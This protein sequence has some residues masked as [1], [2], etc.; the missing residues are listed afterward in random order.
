MVYR[1]AYSDV[2]GLGCFEEEYNGEGG[3]VRSTYFVA[4]QQRL[5]ISSSAQLL[6]MDG[7]SPDLHERA[8]KALRM[9]RRSQSRLTS[10]KFYKEAK[11]LNPIIAVSLKPISCTC[12]PLKS[13][14][15]ITDC[16]RCAAS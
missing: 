4:S 9:L 15:G 5:V 14:F 7:S 12:L 11:I 16:Y 8:D 3:V 13:P 2:E 10:A 6:I 1:K